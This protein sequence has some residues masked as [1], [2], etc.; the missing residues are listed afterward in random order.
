MNLEHLS[1]KYLNEN[2]TPPAS[3]DMGSDDYRIMMEV[4]R[5][6]ED[7]VY[8]YI[9]LANQ[10]KNPKLK[11]VIMDIVQEER[12]HAHEMQVLMKELQSELEADA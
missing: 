6:E 1:K 5:A 3:G 11:K 12:V 7:T 2:F 4:V 10:A 9:E 8:T